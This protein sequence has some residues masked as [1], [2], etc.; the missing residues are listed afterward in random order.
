MRPREDVWRIESSWAGVVIENFNL[1][2][3]DEEPRKGKRKAHR[4]FVYHEE[5][6][7]RG[8]LWS[9]M[10][11]GLPLDANIREGTEGKVYCNPPQLCFRG[12]SVENESFCG[13]SSHVP[14][15]LH[16]ITDLRFFGLWIIEQPRR[17]EFRKKT[18]IFMDLIFFQWVQ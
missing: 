17:R 7:W 9:R 16:T 11:S 4:L 2:D 3:D 18:Y 5:V 14:H 13:S 8:R 1:E 10:W 12:Y 15:H 6:A